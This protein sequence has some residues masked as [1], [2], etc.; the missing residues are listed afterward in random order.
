MVFWKRLWLIGT[1]L[2]W[3]ISLMAAPQIEQWQSEGGAAIYFV[4]APELPMV[5]IEISFAA[6]SGYDGD[7]PG[8][9]NFTASM[10]E[11]GA[12]T[13]DADAIAEGFD[14]LGAGFSAS[15]DRDRISLSLRTLTQPQLL[16][17]ALQLYRL[18]LTEPT[19]PASAVERVREQILVSLTA[20]EQ[21]PASIASR[22]F[23]AALYADHPYAH[24]VSGDKKRVAAIT[25]KEMQQFYQRYF[26]QKNATV[27]VV[28][29]LSRSE[30]EEIVRE[31]LSPLPPGEAA[32]PLPEVIAPEQGAR[33]EIAYPS[34]QTHILWGQPGYRRGDPDKFAL[35]VGNHI[36]G[37]SGLT[38]R[39]SEE[40]RE[41]RGLSYSA[42]SYFVPYRQPGPFT[43]GLQTKNAQREEALSV[44]Q[45]TLTRFIEKG[46][47]EKELV[48][49]KRNIT[50]SFPLNIDSNSDLLAYLSV[51]GFYQL[52]LD[53][54]DTFPQRVEAVTVEDIR[55]V[56][57][58]RIDP[59][60][61]VTVLVGAGS[62]A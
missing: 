1:G 57:R 38:S 42:Y 46:P 21:S 60:K 9:A 32:S 5:D 17:Q 10:V 31:L 27:A 3:S 15:A 29:A 8:L 36:L 37:G 23:Y 44:L 11:E 16:Q 26:V 43:L 59:R 55:R 40:V 18:L 20:A 54:L 56:F 28:G 30:V 7:L 25:A 45:Q 49:A 58:K 24:P 22:R 14:R 50:G 53:Y 4:A 51:I 19:F 2:F 39:I 34:S 6:G 52:P 35:Y 12:G 13:L 33:I 62:G 61:M 47:E 41:K 48:A